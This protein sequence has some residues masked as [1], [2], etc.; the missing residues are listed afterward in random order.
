MRADAQRNRDRIVEVAREVFREQGYDASLDEVAKRA[1]VGAG[2]LYRHFP[3]RE[4]LLDAIMQSWVDRVNEAADKALTHEGPPR[5]LL[6][7]WFEAYVALIS[8]HKGGPAKITSAMGDA[9]SPIV[10]QV[11][12][13]DRRH[14]PGRRPARATE[15]ALRER[16]RR[17]ADRAGSS[18]ASRPWP[19]RAASTRPPYAR[20]SRSSP[21]ACSRLSRSSRDRSTPGRPLR[22]QS[23]RRAGPRTRRPPATAPRRRPRT[24]ERQPHRH[25][26]GGRRLCRAVVAFLLVVP[27]QVEHQDGH[28]RGRDAHPYTRETPADK[29]PCSGE[30]RHGKQG[31]HGEADGHAEQPQAEHPGARQPG[32]V[33]LDPRPEGPH[34]ARDGQADAG[35]HRPEP[36]QQGQQQREERTHPAE[37]QVDQPAHGHH[38]RHPGSPAQGPGGQQPDDADEQQEGGQHENGPGRRRGQVLAG[39]GQPEHRS[40]REQGPAEPDRVLSGTADETQGAEPIAGRSSSHVGPTRTSTPR[41]TQR[42]PSCSV[43]TPVTTGPSTDGRIQAADT[44]ENICGRRAAGST[45]AT[46]TIRDTSI[47]ASAKPLTSRPA[48]TTGIAHARPTSSWAAANAA[49]PVRSTGSGPRRSAHAPATASATRKLAAGAALASPNDARLSKSRTTVGSAVPTARSANA[50]SVTIATVPTDSARCS[51]RRGLTVMDEV[52][53][54]PP[55]KL[56][57]T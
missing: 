19:T 13:A 20:C 23:R 30:R 4:V 1:G 11:P 50:A 10:H 32:V 28:R 18:A 26:R 48:T 51:R 42:Q 33:A 9:D 8:L 17:R 24:A 54:G 6:L 55:C 46:S 3:S 2:T 57:P 7:A 37:R 43:T 25:A 27:R 14:R 16:R 40:S 34:H 5:D 44:S 21:T 56:K 39:E 38:R 36:V 29:T 41:N 47:S 12:D 15:D 31:R 52:L 22:P 49:T 53:M 45:R 35:R